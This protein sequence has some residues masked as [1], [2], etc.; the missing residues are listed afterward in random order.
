MAGLDSGRV[1]VA[2][3]T[4][5][6]RSN[7]PVGRVPYGTGGEDRATIIIVF[8]DQGLCLWELAILSTCTFAPRP[9]YLHTLSSRSHFTYINFRLSQEGQFPQIAQLNLPPL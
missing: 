6:L 3:L 2:G 9:F 8:G 1:P 4:A 7:K 5:S